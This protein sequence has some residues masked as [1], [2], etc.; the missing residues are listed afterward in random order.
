MTNANVLLT[1]PKSV[2]LRGDITTE[3]GDRGKGNGREK[4]PRN[5]GAKV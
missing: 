1:S 3:R 5:G 2:V 4:A